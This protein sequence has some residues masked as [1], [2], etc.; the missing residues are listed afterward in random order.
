MIFNLPRLDLTYNSECPVC[1]KFIIG[2]VCDREK[3]L[4]V[5]DR[6]EYYDID[7][8]NFYRDYIYE[9]PHCKKRFYTRMKTQFGR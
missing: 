9:C 7:G 4:S 8:F 2:H 1:G 6:Y 5:S 3:T